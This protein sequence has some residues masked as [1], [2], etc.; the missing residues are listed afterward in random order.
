MSNFSRAVAIALF[1]W[2]A[3][4][5]AQNGYMLERL[6]PAPAGSGWITLDALDMHGRFSGAASLT[7]SYARDPLPAIVSDE[8]FFDLGASI[9]FDRFRFSLDL[10]SPVAIDGPGAN[11]DLAR[12]PD[13][14][15]DP[16]FGFDV[17]LLGD[18]TSPA[19]LGS[20]VSILLPNGDPASFESDGTVRGIFQLLFAGDLP[21]FAYAARAGVHV[22]RFDA[23]DE[24]VFG[25]AAGARF[26]PSAWS[27]VVGPE[28]FGQTA[29]GDFFGARTGLE[30]LLSA[31]LEHFAPHRPGLR[32]KLGVGAG[33]DPNFGAPAWRLV[34]GVELVGPGASA[35]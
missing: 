30:G 19:R 24:F 22:R 17:R 34:V 12:D 29:L 14:I 10:T 16:R 13:V 4:V 23:G 8:A 26:G 27:V 5:H 31:R 3:P 35:Q 21:H 6:D 11:V 32:A 20:S 28:I 7:V 25:A 1:A 9:T 18:A 2:V 33:L 15:W